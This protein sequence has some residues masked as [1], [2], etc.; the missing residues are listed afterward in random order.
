MR[1]LVHE[2]MGQYKAALADYTD[3][4]AIDAGWDLARAGQG[5]CHRLLGE[6]QEALECY[7]EAIEALGRRGLTADP[8]LGW[9]WAGRA[10][11]HRLLSRHEAA[12]EDATRALKIDPADTMALAVRGKAYWQMGRIVEALADLDRAIDFDPSYGWALAARGDAYRL[13]QRYDEAVAAPP[14]ARSTSTDS[15]SWR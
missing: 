14:P 8:S 2:D 9:I 10:D 5:E 6:F 13:L 1:G 3:V 11:T 12:A 7:S 4:L 15:M